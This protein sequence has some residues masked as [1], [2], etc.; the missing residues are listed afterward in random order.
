M[1]LFVSSTINNIL[2]SV[3]EAF[4]LS[5]HRSTLYP[6]ISVIQKHGGCG[7]SHAPHCVCGSIVS[8][9]QTHQVGERGCCQQAI[10]LRGERHYVKSIRTV[11]WGDSRKFVTS[12]PP[13]GGSLTCKAVALPSWCF[14]QLIDLC[15]ISVNFQI[16][17]LRFLLPRNS[18]IHQLHFMA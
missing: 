17:F 6:H 8:G 4:A 13:G 14:F 3:L 10:D 7:L 12:S 2:W 15:L 1:T 18:V 11:F 9:A 16:F 5:P